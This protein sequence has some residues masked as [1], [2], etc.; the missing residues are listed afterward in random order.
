MLKLN[1]NVVF[2]EVFS[3]LKERYESAS[4]KP[5]LRVSFFPYEHYVFRLSDGLEPVRVP[6]ST[7]CRKRGKLAPEWAVRYLTYEGLKE[8][9][10]ELTRRL[11]V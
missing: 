5:S 4:E 3:E 9:E 11:E 6:F 10:A 1:T 7:F 2:P 8:I